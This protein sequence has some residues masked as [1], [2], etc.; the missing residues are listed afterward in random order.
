MLRRSFCSHSLSRGASIEGTLRYAGGG[1]IGD[2]AAEVFLEASCDGSPTC[3]ARVETGG[4]FKFTGLQDGTYVVLM[5]RGPAG[6]TLQPVRDVSAGTQD[7]ELILQ[8]AATIAGR[9]LDVDGKPARARV[10][11]PSESMTRGKQVRSTDDEGYFR[12]EV[13]PSFR[14]RVFAAHLEN[15]LLRG[16]VQGVSAGQTDLVLQLKETKSSQRR[17]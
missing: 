2:E 6:W 16:E 4:H 14:G 11:V 9:V 12:L 8:K 1:A 15:R 10:W 7:L 3:G 17:K 13:P 5:G